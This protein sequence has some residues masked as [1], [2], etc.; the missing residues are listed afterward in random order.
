MAHEIDEMAPGVHAAAFARQ[1]AWHQLG[2]TLDSEFT[3]LQAMEAAHLGGWNVRKAPVTATDTDGTV[4]AIPDR[5]A[6]LRTNPVTKATEYLGG[7][8]VGSN[9][10]PIQNERHADLLD[11]IVDESGAHF[12]TAGSLRNGREVFISMRMP[13]HL[14][15]GGADRMDLNLVG[16][17]SHDGNSKFR[18]VVTVVRVVCANTQQAALRNAVSTFGVRHDGNADS[19][20]QEAREAL[21]MTF[22]YVEAFEAEAEA[23]LARTATDGWVD[24][25]LARVLEIGDEDPTRT[26]EKHLAGMIELHRSAETLEGIRNTR[27]GAYQTVTEYWDHVAP[28]KG[29]DKAAGRA[30]RTLTSYA[31][32]QTKQRAFELAGGR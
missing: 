20:L 16:L 5:F 32:Q 28:V 7:A 11:T 2:V 27:W 12:D 1:G 6:M 10:Q 23:L 17:N 26:Q 4:I 29:E 15:I 18:F 30:M 21:G 31:T 14:S 3:A 19:R 13:D 9:F 22:R 25:F 8:V 24:K